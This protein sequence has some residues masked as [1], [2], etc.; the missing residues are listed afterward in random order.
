M[1]PAEISEYVL[2][3]CTPADDILRDLAAETRSTFPG[4]AETPGESVMWPAAAV[5]GN[6]GRVGHVPVRD[7]GRRWGNAGRAGR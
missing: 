5:C 1:L 6:A 3:H 4:E 2:A 7:G